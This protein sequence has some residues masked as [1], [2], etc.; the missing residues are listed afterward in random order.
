MIASVRSSERGAA[1]VELSLVLP[2]LLF[3]AA[4]LW[5][6]GRVLDAQVVVSNAAREGARYAALGKTTSAVQDRVASYLTS[7]LGGRLDSSTG[8]VTF[9]RAQV[10]VTNA[11]GFAGDPVSV[12]VPAT[13]R[14]WIPSLI[15][16]PNQVQLSARGTMRL[17][18]GGAGV[19]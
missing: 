13:V 2:T 8:D 1:L 14:F 17:Q 5:E 4:A 18:C 15:G 9:V 7:G 3:L 12:F 6:F 19:C 10:Q 11:R 16:M